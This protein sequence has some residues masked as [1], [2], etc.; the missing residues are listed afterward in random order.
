M[1]ESNESYEEK[2]IRIKDWSEVTGTTVLYRMTWKG[3]SEEDT[4]E[5]RCKI[6]VQWK[7][8]VQKPYS[9]SVPG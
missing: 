6:S 5:Q 2:K 4:F 1:S 9:K 8:Q 7:Q 3:L